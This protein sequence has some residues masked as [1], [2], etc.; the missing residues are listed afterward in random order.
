[1]IYLIVMTILY[2]IVVVV[3]RTSLE[4]ASIMDFV[5]VDERTCCLRLRGEFF[6]TTLICIHSPTEEKETE[7]NSFYDKLDRVY[8]KAPAHTLKLSWGILTQK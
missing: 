6:N 2:A 3:I 1:M 7:K 5:P 4:Q 8:Q